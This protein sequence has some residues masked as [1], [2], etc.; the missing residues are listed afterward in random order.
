ME[1]KSAFLARTTIQSDI[2]NFVSIQVSAE[3]ETTITGELNQRGEFHVESDSVVVVQGDAAC[4]CPFTGDGE[5]VFE[6]GFHPIISNVSFEGSLLLEDTS[7]TKIQLS[8]TGPQQ[9]D[10]FNVDG[11]LTL[12]GTLEI[13]PT[14]GY[15]PTPGDEFLIATAQARNGIFDSIPED[16]SV[17]VFGHSEVFITYKAGDGNDIG[18]FVEEVSVL[19][20]DVN[21]D[22]I[23][24][25]LDVQPFV[26]LL[27]VGPFQPEADINK[28]GLVNLL[29]VAGFVGLL[30][31]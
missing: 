28:D 17:G 23:V 4:F 15:L 3:G 22:G 21:L 31:G 19:L 10:R 24:N 5:L 11:F 13:E 27:S 2:N 20:G 14:N 9:F 30:A 12:R 25:L 1:V 8:G 26:L 6:A 18:L 7:T 29:D 16:A